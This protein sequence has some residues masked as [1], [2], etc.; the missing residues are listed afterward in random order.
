MH[1]L[2]FTLL[3]CL[4]GLP[5]QTL[6]YGYPDV[7]E[8]L[9]SRQ[10]LNDPILKE[11]D[12][13]IVGGG[14]SGLVIASRLSEDSRSK[15]FAFFHS[16]SPLIFLTESVLVVEHGDF[17]T[18]PAQLDPPS[19]SIV[20]PRNLYNY[21]V[22]PQRGLNNRRAFSFAAAVVGGGSTINGMVFDRGSARDYDDW[23]RFGNPGWGFSDLLPYFKKARG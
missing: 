5:F 13:I 20:F 23:E 16:Q 22:L 9:R 19:S 12:Y 11:Y 1:E 7:I 21:T 15:C 18:S 4:A 6:V 3:V 8:D 17:E 10:T 14:Q 2:V